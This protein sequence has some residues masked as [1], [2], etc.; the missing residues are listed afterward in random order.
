MNA[1]SQEAKH[2]INIDMTVL[3]ELGQKWSAYYYYN[4]WY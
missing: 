1:G 4:V 3:W 2:K